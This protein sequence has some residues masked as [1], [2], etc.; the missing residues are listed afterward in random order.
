VGKGN[1]MGGKGKGGR[2]MGKKGSWNR[3]TDLLRLALCV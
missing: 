2:K 3:A 1:G